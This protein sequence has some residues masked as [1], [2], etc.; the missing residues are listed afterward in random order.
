MQQ[1]YQQAHYQPGEK[2]KFQNPNYNPLDI[3][4]NKGKRVFTKEEE[5]EITEYILENIIKRGILFTNYDFKLLVMDA[6]NE[7]IMDEDNY[8]NIP[9]FNA[10]DGFITDFKN[11]NNFVS[12]RHHAAKRSLITN[13]AD[14]FAKQ[15]NFLFMNVEPCYIINI[16]ET[17][18][19]VIPKILKC[20]H[21]KG[22]DHVLRYVNSNCKE[23]ITVIAGVRA[24]WEVIPK[25]TIYSYRKD[26][27]GFR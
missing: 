14:V 4:T 26:R 16:D 18:W 25:I 15:M 17:S 22:R 24:S 21:V 12:R 3:N 6:F 7:K 27:K 23:R 13:F 2:N 9:K 19:E 1:E 20:W 5:D 11:R 8:D 10:S